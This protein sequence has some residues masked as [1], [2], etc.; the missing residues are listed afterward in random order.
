LRERLLVLVPVWIGWL[1]I[2]GEEPSSPATDE[3]DATEV[4]ALVGQLEE[5]RGPEF[6]ASVGK[7][8]TY[9]KE[10]EPVLVAQLEKA[11]ERGRLACAKALLSLRG[12][13]AAA[14]DRPESF[15]KAIK[16][17]KELAA[18]TA[19][20]EV[21]VAAMG[22]L[23]SHDDPDQAYEFLHAL[24]DGT[25]DP[26]IKVPLARTL[27]DLDRVSE[28]RDYLVQVL[29]TTRD[30][31]LK[32]EA[33]LSLAEIDYF[34][35]EVRD[36]LRTLKDEPSDQGR[37]AAALDRVL[38]LS[39]Q[40]DRGL[41]AGSVLPD[42]ADP[43]KLLEQKSRRIAEL[44]EE[45][46][47]A[48]E[49]K[50]GGT[51]AEAF[52]EEVIRRIQESYVD[53]GKTDRK[54]LIVNAAKGM[55][56][57]LDEFSSFLDV[58]TAASFQE[59]MAGKYDGVGAQVNK[60]PGAPLEIEKLFYGGPAHKAG[61]LS[62]DRILEVD[63]VPTDQD[64]IQE[65]VEKLKG[66]STSTVALRVLRRE[67]NEPR[68][69][70]L[71]R[72][73]V[74]VP[75]VH[76]QVLPGKIGFLALQQFGQRSKEEFVEALDRLEAEGIEA[77]VLDLRDNGG[78]YFETAT[79]MAD[80][81][82]GTSEGLPIAT[83]KGRGRTGGASEEI[84]AQPDPF[85]RPRYPMIVLTNERSASA[86]EVLAGA[87]QDF[88]RALVVGKRTFGKG[89][90]Q[91]VIDLSAGAQSFLGGEGRLRLTV[92]YYF[93]PLGR[94]VHTIRDADGRVVE[95][96]GVQPDI[97]VEQEKVPMWRI[98]E[99]EKTRRDEAVLDYVHAHYGEV[100]H[101]FLAGDA[102]DT[103]RYP[104]FDDLFTKVGGRSPRDDLRRVLRL[105][106]RR[107]LEDERGREFACDHQEDRQLQ[108]A[109][110]EALRRLGKSPAE[111]PEYAGLEST[112]DPDEP[113]GSEKK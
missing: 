2:A 110:L 16:A 102:R 17:L 76:H 100:K 85:M 82:L 107:R 31:R 69:F 106:V 61:L 98:E 7:L 4:A 23:G 42:G 25:Q 66:P 74:E 81:F 48:G 22:L 33:A 12:D 35:G 34:E 112:A 97:E 24:F 71:E 51:P 32:Q 5:R 57:S 60:L 93:L 28:A 29:S 109:V 80:Q 21:R 84:V 94:C 1:P 56:S 62:G 72:G 108:R 26:E 79:Q 78:G 40:L 59:S 65:I 86:S 68:E 15:Q 14:E 53:P 30:V 39:R 103:S 43:L 111:F 18:G 89:S 37:R 96:G 91:R 92:Q 45:I 99:F 87:L 75:S 52:L 113:A 67:W 3:I 8:E 105:L 20:K 49:R 41:E 90:V 95:I 55:V 73:K 101:L 6:W 13:D 36:V 46:G 44:E 38:K 70:V 19:A 58:E 77:L 47:R 9:A 88:G 50:G 27:W 10:A 83:R 11:G 63:G 54:P 64:E 104:G